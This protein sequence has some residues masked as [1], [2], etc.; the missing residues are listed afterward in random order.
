MVCPEGSFLREPYHSYSLH[1]MTPRCV[2]PMEPC[3]VFYCHGSMALTRGDEE[4]P[5]KDGLAEDARTRTKGR[6]RWRNGAMAQKW[7]CGGRAQSYIGEALI[8]HATAQASPSSSSLVCPV[9]G[10]KWVLF[11][12]RC[13]AESKW[14]PCSFLPKLTL[15]QSLVGIQIQG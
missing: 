8:I 4:G 1:R 7:Q 3:F 11:A 9:Q 6:Q 15:P 5:S 2:R 10:P 14:S 13:Q 12:G